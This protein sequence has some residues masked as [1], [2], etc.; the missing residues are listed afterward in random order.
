[1]FGEVNPG[2]KL[3][4]TMYHANYTAEIVMIQMAMSVV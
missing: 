2:G 4:S 1:L 3:A